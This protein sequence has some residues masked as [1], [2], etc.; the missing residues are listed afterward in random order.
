MGYYEDQLAQRQP[1]A[2]AAAPQ[3]PVLGGG[4]MWE[5]A[6]NP[7]PP[8]VDGNGQPFYGLPGYGPETGLGQGSLANRP[9]AFES[10][11]MR[12][13][14]TNAERVTDQI[15]NFQ[16]GGYQ[17]GATDAVGA[18][19]GAIG[20]YAQT[21]GGYGDQFMGQAAQGA[22]IMGQ[23]VGGMYGQ[24]DAL[25]NYAQQGPGPSV[26]QAQLDA[27]T[28]QAMRQQLAMA[29]SGRGAG[30]GAAAYRQAA[31]NQ[32]QLQGGANAQAAMLQAQEAQNWRQAQIAAMQGA[33][34]LYG[35]GANLGGQYATNMGG[36]AA[37]AQTAA[38]QTALGQEQLV[39]DINKAAL[40]GSSQYEQNMTDIY[41]IASGV[42]SQSG[43]PGLGEALF[44]IGGGIAGAYFGGPVGAAGGA[45]GGNMAYHALDQGF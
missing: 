16:Y 15:G 23:G 10:S 18:A 19:R 38:G 26:A 34:S 14:Q 27:N 32:A 40:A 22:G 25:S 30:G 17:G 4:T 7:A 24:A 31:A 36:M 41:G 39:N 45:Q 20:P 13:D 44:T 33:G 29:G 42:P 2:P 1:V 21:L 28:G 6:F 12:W 43:S 35:E 5:G 37:S 8:P 9:V 3:Q 11:P